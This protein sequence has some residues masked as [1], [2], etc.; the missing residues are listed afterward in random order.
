MKTHLELMASYNQWMNKAI[1]SALSGLEPAELGKD[2][3]AFFGSIIG[4]LNHILVGD[5]IWLKRFSAHP[6]NFSTLEVLEEFALP[7]SLADIIHPHIAPLTRA[8]DRMDSLIID[9][10][11]ETR[12]ADLAYNLNY[13]NTQ[14]KAFT[15]NFAH[16]LQHLFN[17]QTH[18]RGQVSTLL[19]QQGIDIASSDLLM[20]I[21][22]A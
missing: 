21:P 4:T 14:G 8:R 10:I 20:M 16:L 13:S 9:L 22:D 5:I 12:A 15:K 18:H 6:A 3:G 19:H 1:F 17:H 11:K 7:S 2:R